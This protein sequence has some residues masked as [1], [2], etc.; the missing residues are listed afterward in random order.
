MKKAILKQ[1]VQEFLEANY[2]KEASEIALQGSPF[3]EISALELA[4]QLAGKKKAFKK[5]PQWFKTRG[6]VYPPGVNIEQT[7]SQITAQY[8][9][10]LIEGKSLA[11]LSGGLG[12]D[13]YYFSKKIQTV[14]HCEINNELSKIAAHNLGLL[15]AN[16]IKFVHGD[17]VEFLKTNQD[18]FDWLY[19]DPSR[20]SQSGGRVFRLVDCEPNVPVELD[21][22]L[23]KTKNLMLKTSPLLDISAGL[24]E[25]KFVSEIH[26]IAVKN[27][28][29]E[30]LWMLSGQPGPLRINTL[31]FTLKG[32]EKFETGSI[33]QEQV[34]I[35]PPE[36]FLYEP[37]AAIMKSGMFS[38]LATTYGLSKLHPN[39]HLFTSLELVDFP[40]RRFKIL[41]QLAYNPKKIKKIIGATKAN[42]SIRNFPESVANLRKTF[43]IKDGGDVYLFFT[44]L[45]NDKRVALICEKIAS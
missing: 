31:N 6:V 20:R 9:A 27:E 12:V 35:G 33:E 16:N 10:S 2:Q 38:S 32:L 7:S 1:E 4:T 34:H 42:I 19:I 44:T 29:K 15:G 41:D 36:G 23:S 45:D 25:L 3:P 21:F 5:L 8:K 40:G 22:L 14:Y 37:N 17:A 39:T 13:S 11:D 30:L 43:K 18:I 24:E 28:V 26:I